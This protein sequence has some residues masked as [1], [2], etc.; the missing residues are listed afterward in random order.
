MFGWIRHDQSQCPVPDG[1]IAD[2]ILNDGRTLL[3][4]R[5]GGRRWTSRGPDGVAYYRLTDSRGEA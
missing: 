1:A 3:S 5:C 2:L 4:Q